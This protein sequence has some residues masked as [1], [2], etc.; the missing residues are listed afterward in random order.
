MR[1]LLLLMLDSIFPPRNDALI[2]RSLSE[3]DIWNLYLR[4]EHDSF[5][6]LSSYHDERIRALIHEAKFYA[7]ARAWG[8]LHT[9]FMHS[10]STLPLR[11][12]T[13]IPIPLSKKRMRERGYNQV[14][15]IISLH[16]LPSHLC[17]NTTILTRIVDTKPQ[18]KLTRNERLTNLD[19]AFRVEKPEWVTGKHLLLIDDVATTGT[20]L[21]RASKE[22][23]KHHP[24]SITCIA[25]AH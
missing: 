9:L 8:F 4:T 24:T 22:L 17:L 18:V 15:K 20:T 13:V 1:K 25:L 19:G 16:P 5:I 14:E 12:Y 2:V 21:G 3:E 11:P 10:V 23:L 7:D 6:S